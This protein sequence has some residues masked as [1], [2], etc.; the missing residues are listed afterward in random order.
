MSRVSVIESYKQDRYFWSVR[1]E[2][3]ETKYI[4]CKNEQEAFALKSFLDKMIDSGS[5]KWKNKI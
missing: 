5:L 2:G 3:N 4:E 1:L